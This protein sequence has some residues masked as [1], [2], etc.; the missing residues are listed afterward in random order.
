MAHDAGKRYLIGIQC[1]ALVLSQDRAGARMNAFF[2]E[3]FT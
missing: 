1:C 3:N 2:R